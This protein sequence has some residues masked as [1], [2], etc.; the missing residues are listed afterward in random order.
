MGVGDLKKNSRKILLNGILF[1]LVFGLT[2]YGVFWG[3][4][5]EQVFDAVRQANILWLFPA[6]VCVLVFIWG[7]SI[8]LWYMMRSYGLHMKERHCF[9]VSSVGFFFSCVTPSASVSYTHL[10]LP[11]IA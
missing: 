1:F 3:E 6:I 4:D 7:E 2:L 5:L 8:I 9:L 11:T 10:T